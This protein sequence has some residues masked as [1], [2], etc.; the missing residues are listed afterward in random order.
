MV[1]KFSDDF[2]YFIEDSCAYI[3]YAV[4]GIFILLAATFTSVYLLRIDSEVAET[5]YT[6]EN[7]NPRQNAI[8][9]ASFDLARCLNYAGMEALEWQ[10]EHPVILPEGNA[11]SRF[12]EDGFML[13]PKNQNLEREDMLQ[14]SINL[15]SDIW[16]KI[17]ALWKNR[18]IMLIVNDSSG[19]EIKNVNYGQATGFFQ[20][21]S[22]Q[23]EV[24]I[25]DSAASGYASIELYYGDELKA[26]DWFVIEASPVKDI[27]ADAFNTLLATNYQRNSHTFREYAINVEPDIEPEQIK[28]RKVTGTLQREISPAD[29][30]YTIYYVFE[31]PALNYTLVNLESGESLN[32]SMKLST[33]ITSRE[34]LLEELVREYE[35]E[36]ENTSSLD[37]TSNLVLGATNLRT[38]VY[39]P[40][41]HYANGPLNI[42]TNPA[43]SGSING[44]TLYTQKRIFDSVDPLALTYTSYYNGKVLYEDVFTSRKKETGSSPNSS[45]NSTG[46][47]NSTSLNTSGSTYET[48]KGVNLTTTYDSLA[49]NK[50]FSL[51]VEKSIGESLKATNTSFEELSEGSKIELSAS[52]YTDGVLDGWIFNDHVWTEENPDLI[53]SITD[54]V[55]TASV[56]GQ[57]LRDGF[58]SPDPI[59]SLVTANFD[60]DSVSFRGQTVRWYST[61]HASGTHRGSLVPSYSWRYS[62]RYSYSES[63]S[64]LIDPPEGDVTS[65]SVTSASVSLISVDIT[66]VKIEPH[67]SYV[68]NDTLMVENRSE[69]YLNRED[70]VFDWRIRYDI[71]YKIRTN[72]KIDYAYDYTYR[73]KTRE[74]LPDGNYTTVTHSDTSSDSDSQTISK[75]NTESLSHAETEAEKLTVIYHKCPPAGGYSGLL[76]YSDSIEREYRETTLYLN[77][78]GNNGIDNGTGNNGIDNGTDSSTDSSITKTERFD[79]CCS[80]AADKYRDAYVDLRAI[81]STFWA[82]PDGKYLPKHAVN[83][84]IP[85]WL[86]RIMA[87]EVLAM[88]DSVEKDNPSFDYSFIDSPGQDPT[89]LQVETAEKLIL[90]LEKTRETYINKEQYLT[91]SGAMYASSDSARYIAKNE[92]YNKLLED[93]DRKNRKLDSDLNSYILKALEKKGLDT[94]L[95]DSVTSGPMTLFNNPAIEKAASALGEDMGIISTM[96]VTGQPE[97]KYNWTENLTLIIDQKPNYLYH[98]PDF[99]LRKE[100]EWADSMSGK[101]IYPLGVRN[102]C[103][104]T[105]GISEEIGDIIS[106]SNEYVKT[107]MAQQISQSISNLDTEVFLLE[108]N[109]SE[110]NI[111][112]DTT[113]LDRE[114]YNLKHIYV[115]EMRSQILENVVGE[116]SSNP[117]I[118]DCIEDN[119]IRE[120]TTTYLN[121]LSDNEI[122]EKSTTDELAVELA[123]VIKAEIRNSNPP[124]EPD[125]LE[126]IL[127]RVDTDIKLGVAN[128]ICAVTVNKGEVIDV[129]FGRIDSELKNLANETSD[130]YSGEIGNKISKKLDRTMTAVPCGLPVLPPHWIFTVNVWTYEIVGKYEEFTVIDNDNEVIPEPYFG[131]KG[132]KF[133]REQQSIT[134]NEKYLGENKPITFR[135]NGYASTIVGPGPKGVGDKVKG[136]TEESVGYQDLLLENGG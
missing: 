114:V 91:P 43:L 71:S 109:L 96:T 40:W 107:E 124:V 33:L 29:K 65:W 60:P 72:W 135:F 69:G 133:V 115:Q 85:S 97:N 132:Q 28:I 125:E 31:I 48:N 83:C 54:S 12:S 10:G 126:A 101:T 136:M 44:A 88:L 17:E 113:R 32:S 110:Q 74:Q 27:A 20:K 103:I 59:T 111:S 21:V 119:R 84:D 9:L 130:R 76:T 106:S 1:G 104:F 13:I 50:S 123:S 66:D 127:N 63:L 118:S 39:G 81:E 77:N 26:S 2:S 95:L 47:N 36:L 8:N 86:H 121:G 38:F 15:P 51:D 102:T 79:P 117:V 128:G 22:L 122:L 99:D 92:A 24:E 41:Q 105:T 7:S 6:T 82:Y 53:H 100:Y 5:I 37:S 112:L 18:D 30:N 55:Y 131:H 4:I 14:I 57:V 58:D 23:E 94:G 16:G 11:V 73:W 116:V 68:S 75:T 90:E 70:H 61:Y 87:E 46:L 19:R 89:A 34:P 93:I 108:Q 67:F 56:Q 98:D 78:T 129:G 134:L 120:V 3:P 45:L 52:D 35:T 25:P 42:L 80:D 49:Q 62:T 64:P